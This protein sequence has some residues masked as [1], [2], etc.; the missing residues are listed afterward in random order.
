MGDE[1]RHL[2]KRLDAVSQIAR[3][4]SAALGLDD[5]LHAVYAAIA[6]FFTH[7]AYMVLRYSRSNDTIKLLF[8]T[9]NNERMEDVEFSVGGFSGA[10]V[11][12]ERSLYVPD[13]G[14][15]GTSLPQPIIVGKRELK[16]SWLGVPLRIRDQVTGVLVLMAR[17]PNAYGKD[18]ELL[19]TTVA[20]Q[21]AIAIDNARLFEETRGQAERLALLNRVSKAVSSQLDQKDLFAALY[22]EITS[23]FDHDEFLVVLHEAVQNELHI[24]FGMM[25]GV[26]FVP[27]RKPFGGLTGVVIGERKTLHIRDYAEEENNLPLPHMMSGETKM[28]ASW[29]GVPLIV[30][31]RV[32]G[33]LCIMIDRPH[34]YGPETVRLFETIADQ[35]GFAI[36]NT[37]YFKSVRDAAVRLSIVNRIGRA[38]SREQDL[39]KLA[40]KVHREIAPV[41]EADTFYVALYDEQAA[42]IAFP[43][44]TD[45]GTRVEIDP[46]EYGKGLTSTV[47]RT[48]KTL[49]TRTPDEYARA[50]GTAISYGS[51]KDP[52]SWLG[53]PLLIEG[54]VIGVINVQSYRSYAYTDDQVLLLETIAD[55]VATSFE[56]ALLFQSAQRELDE[57]TRAEQRLESERTLLRTII[58]NIPDFI[59]AK[60]LDGRF[61]VANAS[62]ASFFGSANE[63][64][65]LGRTI[66]DILPKEMAAEFLAEEK[67]IVVSGD[68]V[69]NKEESV[70][71]QETGDLVWLLVTK[72][73]LVD[74]QGQVI[75]LVG[76]DRDITARKLA[77]EEV[78]RY[79]AEIEVANEEVKTFAYIVSHDL[80]APLVN[81]KGFSAELKESMET[82]SPHLQ[83]LLEGMDEAQRNDLSLVLEEDIP[84]ALGFI[85]TSVTRM[86]GFINSVLRLSRIGRRELA[87]APV[88][89]AEFVET[90]RQSLA[91]QMEARQVELIV[92]DL[93]PVVADPTAMEQIIGNLLT[94]AVNYL[95]P[96]RPGRI[97]IGAQKTPLG[98][99]FWIKDNGRGISKDDDEKVFA[100]FR[101]AGRQDVKGEGMGLSYVRT[102]VRQ[103]GGQI[104]FESEPGVGTTFFFT[105]ADH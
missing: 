45:E 59:Y 47:I 91:H 43:F 29:L 88:Q 10:V 76:I 81:L 99:K 16:G 67:A 70:I 86:D 69:L 78:K 21:L 74:S 33:A 100:P 35:I 57:R 77:E 102:M 51:E 58:N 6:P 34:A 54:C 52:V 4:T 56:K 103:H 36:S 61:V 50:S 38:V 80:R 73:P 37:E 42:T 40:E 96:Q 7:D 39:E 66:G 41:F 85:E 64:A 53:I 1:R 83:K 82:L 68:P 9:I 2:E 14:N 18:D 48:K 3:V 23:V 26:R 63:E 55:Q 28:P 49:H 5:L 25:N 17:S 8:G 94:N 93:P 12:E 20:D 24:V 13:V 71:H 19:L 11:R 27:E 104:W 101:R 65:I 22:R 30:G 84:E 92:N 31:D 89:V 15:M 95:D 62:I 60:D 87:P 72:L 90:C 32:L 97:E 46:I 44:M 75:G 105:I 79:L 98:T